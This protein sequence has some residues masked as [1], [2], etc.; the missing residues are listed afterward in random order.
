MNCDT[1]VD[2]VTC[3]NKN[4]CDAPFGILPAI[5]HHTDSMAPCQEIAAVRL[6]SGETQVM[7]SRGQACDLIRTAWSCDIESVNN[8][9]GCITSVL[10]ATYDSLSL[11]ALPFGLEQ[12]K[13]TRYCAITRART[14]PT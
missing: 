7:G 9:A 11:F 3:Y 4:C 5:A 14:R 8:I 13:H 12:E 6:A 10:S 2:K 1:G